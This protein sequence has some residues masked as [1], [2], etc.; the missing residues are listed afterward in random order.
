V[1]EHV[2]LSYHRPPDRTDVFIQE[3]L[4]EDDDVLITY[5]AATPLKRP[6][7]VDG[8][9]V[10]ENGSPAIWFTFP[11]LMHDIGRFHLPDGRF[12][13]LYSNIME[14][15]TLHSRLDWSATDLFLDLWIGEGRAPCILDR[16]E[17]DRAVSN[18]WIGRQTA[19][20]ALNEADE[21]LRRYRAGTWPPP[22][23]NDW[24]I[25]RVRKNL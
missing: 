7:V 21:L 4:Y 8:D 1:T 9:V 10:L 3:L 23:V 16:D 6:L 12:T 19:V 18:E 2:R 25:S 20:D 24:P 22:I 14:P 11:G 13:G 17:L 15:V 5:L